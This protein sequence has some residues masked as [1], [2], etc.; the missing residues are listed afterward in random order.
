MEDLK[1][2]IV[3]QDFF[4]TILNLNNPSKI[5]TNEDIHQDSIK[6]DFLSSES[7]HELGMLKTKPKRVGPIK[8]QWDPGFMYDWAMKDIKEKWAEIVLKQ[9]TYYESLSR[10]VNLR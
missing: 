5:K 3:R 6:T 2:W 10:N 4:S 8:F 7:K 1:N 9:R